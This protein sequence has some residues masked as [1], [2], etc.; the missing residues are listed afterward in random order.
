MEGM[1]VSNNTRVESVILSRNGRDIPAEALLNGAYV[2]ANPEVFLERVG[3]GSAHDAYVNLADGFPVDP[4]SASQEVHF[5]ISSQRI[6]DLP[7]L[8]EQFHFKLQGGFLWLKEENAYEDSVHLVS[9]LQSWRDSYVA[10]EVAGAT[11]EDQQTRSSGTQSAL[12]P[13]S[14]SQLLLEKAKPLGRRVYPYLPPPLRR[15]A[16]RSWGYLL[17]RTRS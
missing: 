6:S 10:L 5:Y 3:A 11:A 9:L 14:R 4:T 2:T 1:T 15:L 12:P 7:D 17:R 8:P 16:L 13:T